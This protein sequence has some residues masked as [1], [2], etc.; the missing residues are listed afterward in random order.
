MER[1]IAEMK[2]NASAEVE[3]MKNKTKRSL[4]IA[5]E[6]A[7]KKKRNAEARMKIKELI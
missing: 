2:K 5:D 7:A 1:E 4:E 6:D 3:E